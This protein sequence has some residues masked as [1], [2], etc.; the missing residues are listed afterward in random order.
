MKYNQHG[1]TIESQPQYDPA[2]FNRTRLQAC[3]IGMGTPTGNLPHLFAGFHRQRS[4]IV[5]EVDGASAS[6]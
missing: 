3:N 1:S 6:L 5:L 2:S 4:L